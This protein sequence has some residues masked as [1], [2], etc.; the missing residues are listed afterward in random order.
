MQQEMKK[1]ITL[2]I[3]EEIARRISA[4]AE[5]KGVSVSQLTEN[6]FRD[7]LNEFDSDQNLSPIVRK[8]KGIIS[9]LV[10]AKRHC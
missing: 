1:T 4:Y 8:Y 10:D 7:F 3:D 5:S 6:S 9:E 2:S